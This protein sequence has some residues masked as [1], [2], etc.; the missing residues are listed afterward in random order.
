[1]K[2]SGLKQRIRDRKTVVGLRAPISA[3]RDYFQRALD[4]EAYEFVFTD[5]QHSAVDDSQLVAFCALADEFDLP[6]RFRPKHALHCKLIGNLLDFGVGGV[7]IPQ[8]EC[9][10][11]AY[12]AIDNFY[13]PPFGRRSIGGGA[14]LK[15]E[16]YADD[17]LYADWWNGNG[18]LWLQIESLSAVLHAHKLAKPEVDCLSIGPNDLA[19]D[20][21]AHPNPPYKTVEECGGA[22]V[23]TIE[24]TNTAVCFRTGTPERRQVFADLG[25]TVFLENPKIN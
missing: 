4:Q 18:V 5:G 14:R 13:Y 20:I 10:Q 11:T 7:E 2:A 1:M 23:R 19:F 8:T 6:V 21:E 17:R 9:E 12:E 3:N 24:N 16:N 25:V 15:I 22:V